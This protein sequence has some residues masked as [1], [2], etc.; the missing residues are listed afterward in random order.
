MLCHAKQPVGGGAAHCQASAV[1]R[2]SAGDESA[3]VHRR[4]TKSK[5]CLAGLTDHV[6]DAVADLDVRQDHLLLLEG[7]G[8][9]R[10]G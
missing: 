2:R 10:F 7:V 9:L 4:V 3:H 8:G 6:H 1:L 5:K